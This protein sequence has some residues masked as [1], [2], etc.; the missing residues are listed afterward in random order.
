MRRP[1]ARLAGLLL[2]TTLCSAAG[3]ARADACPDANQDIVT[4]R[5]SV[6]NSSV[7]VPAG[8]L[9]MENGIN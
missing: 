3:C 8:S 4:D 6:T 5:P 1:E 2:A 7:V 9:Q